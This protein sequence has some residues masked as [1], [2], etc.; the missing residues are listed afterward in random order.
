[1]AVQIMAIDPRAVIHA[2]ESKA[3]RTTCLT[4]RKAARRL[5]A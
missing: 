3:Q 4:A 2:H 1:M 5:S